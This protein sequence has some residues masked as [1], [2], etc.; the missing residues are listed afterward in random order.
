M[1]IPACAF[2]MVLPSRVAREKHEENCIRSPPLT[3]SLK[4][5]NRFPRALSLR[6]SVGTMYKMMVVIT[7]SLKMNVSFMCVCNAPYFPAVL[8]EKKKPSVPKNAE[9]A[10]QEEAQPKKNDKTGN[11][12]QY[13]DEILDHGQHRVLFTGAIR[14]IRSLIN[15]VIFIP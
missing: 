1:C 3:C 13:P 14:I 4:L 11:I 7:I 5:I 15:G 9:I 6:L 8:Q 10:D 12:W 2:R